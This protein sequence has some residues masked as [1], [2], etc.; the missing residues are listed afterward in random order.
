MA[1]RSTI[2]A[3]VGDR[4]VPAHRDADVADK[5]I[6]NEASGDAESGRT[7]I[8]VPANLVWP[9]VAVAMRFPDVALPADS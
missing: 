7:I 6:A 3:F 8:G 9:I 4:R 2:Q 1:T 5:L